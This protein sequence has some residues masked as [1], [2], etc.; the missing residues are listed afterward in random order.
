M[1][2]PVAA[3]R[4]PNWLHRSHSIIVD[5]PWLPRHSIVGTLAAGPLVPRCPLVAAGSALALNGMEQEQAAGGLHG[6]LA[7][8]AITH[9]P[10]LR[11]AAIAEASPAS[12]A[13]IT[14][15][16]DAR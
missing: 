9:Q 14:P 7:S 15:G 3:A 11:T 16:A 8:I 4:R 6:F 10:V 12:A 5:W 1:A 13:S 2:T